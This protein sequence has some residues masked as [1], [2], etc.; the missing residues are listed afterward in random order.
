[1]IGWALGL[2]LVLSTVTQWIGGVGFVG[3]ERAG[4]ERATGKQPQD[5]R[6]RWRK[7]FVPALVAMK[8]R[9]GWGTRIVGLIGLL[10]ANSLWE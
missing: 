8:L 3:N 4:K 7:V 6:L 10:E 2:L 5:L 9:Q 1:M